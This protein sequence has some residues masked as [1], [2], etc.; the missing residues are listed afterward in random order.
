MR[1]PTENQGQRSFDMAGAAKK[2]AIGCG[3]GCG[4]MIII[5]G[6]IGTCGY[7]GVKKIADDA[8][9]LDEGFETLEE[10]YGEPGDFTP[11]MDG[12]IRSE[13]LEVF[14]DI[15][16]DLATPREELGDILATLDD[17]GG[18][19]VIDKI[20][21]GFGLVPGLFRFIDQR[22]QVLVERG[23]GLG[24][25]SHIY[26][27]AY[28]A[29][30]EKDPGDG[31]G[32]Q[33]NG[34]D[35]GEGSVRWGVHTESG[36]D[37]RERREEDIRRYLHRIQRRMLENQIAAAEAGALEEARLDELRAEASR[38]DDRSRRLLWENELP[39]PLRESLEPF[40]TRLEE[41]Y[42]PQVNA[43]EM[44]LMENN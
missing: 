21:A 18:G 37:E 40:R 15:R 9:G 27:V 23:M 33:L 6:G 32:F 42:S 1:T 28:F 7:L 25:Y 36:G 38:M 17:E 29:W 4:L 12:T 20:K 19:N 22:N 10:V 44:G 43:V 34:D 24:E 8:E 13:R 30:L 3:I 2:W 5:A 31:P 11:E 41:S 26:S 39:E 35:E 16:Q 14:L